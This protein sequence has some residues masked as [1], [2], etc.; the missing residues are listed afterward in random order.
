MEAMKVFWTKLN[1]FVRGESFLHIVTMFSIVAFLVKLFP[2]TNY[3]IMATV[4]IGTALLW[5]FLGKYLEGKTI[6][7]KDILMTII[8]GV[9]GILLFKIL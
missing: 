1:H 5:E 8:G 3:Y 4:I 6:N 9:I 2:N 7:M